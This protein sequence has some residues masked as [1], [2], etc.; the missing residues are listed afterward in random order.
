MPLM[1]PHLYE[2]VLRQAMAEQGE[3]LRWYIARVDSST[4]VAECVL[5]PHEREASAADEDDRD[6][7]ERIERSKQ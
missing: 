2:G 1:A 6:G 5:L 3:L 4:A 7:D